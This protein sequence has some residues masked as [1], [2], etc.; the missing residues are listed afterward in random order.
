METSCSAERDA[1]ATVVGLLN[2]FGYELAGRPKKTA[3]TVEE[4]WT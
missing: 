4:D 1:R 3:G 2:L